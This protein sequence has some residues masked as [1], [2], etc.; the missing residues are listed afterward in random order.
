MEEYKLEIDVASFTRWIQELK[1]TTDQKATLVTG[2]CH[3]TQAGS[4]KRQNLR[5]TPKSLMWVP[6]IVVASGIISR[7]IFKKQ[8]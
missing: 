1:S 6:G 4:E 7:D 5:I 3:R 2:M 8:L